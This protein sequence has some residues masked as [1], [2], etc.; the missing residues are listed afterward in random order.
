MQLTWYQ[1]ENN[2]DLTLTLQDQN[3][4]PTDDKNAIETLF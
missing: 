4:G 1:T 3:F 2:F